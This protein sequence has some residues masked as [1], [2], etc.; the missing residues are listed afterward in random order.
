MIRVAPS[1]SRIGFGRKSNDAERLTICG[2]C[3]LF[4]VALSV[5]PYS[6]FVHETVDVADNFDFEHATTA[7]E[8]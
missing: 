3:H 4:L 8:T 5:C 2:F 6:S 7:V 1:V